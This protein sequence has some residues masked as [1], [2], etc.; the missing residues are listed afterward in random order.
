MSRL[1]NIL[2][3]I[4]TKLNSSSI[5]G[6]M[7]GNIAIVTVSS[8]GNVASG[9]WVNIGKIAAGQRPET[10]LFEL[11]GNGSV[12][13]FGKIYITPDGDIRAYH[14]LGSTQAL[15]GATLI[16]AVYRS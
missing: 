9:T 7:V 16:Y 10:G 8:T 4:I 11:A 3:T 1:Y 15:V 12:N 14:A 2:N 5:E 13:G 6:Y